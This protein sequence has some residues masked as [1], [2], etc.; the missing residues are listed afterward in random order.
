MDFR[1]LSEF[2]WVG[3]AHYFD[4]PIQNH[5]TVTQN[6]KFLRVFPCDQKQRQM[7]SVDHIPDPADHKKTLTAGTGTTTIRS[8]QSQNQKTPQKTLQAHGKPQ[9]TTVRPRETKDDHT[10]KPEMTTNDD[11]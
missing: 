7:T 2:C 6:R 8:T 4:K 1:F 9:M 11:M 3:S 10:L 5:A